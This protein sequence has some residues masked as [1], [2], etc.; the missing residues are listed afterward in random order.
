MQIANHL[1]DYRISKR[2]IALTLL[3]ANPS[4]VDTLLGG[5]EKECRAVKE[6]IARTQSEVLEPLQQL[7][8]NA[9]TACVERLIREC[10]TTGERAGVPITIRRFPGSGIHP[11]ALGR[12]DAVRHPLCDL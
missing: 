8:M 2:A 11:P 3:S 6:I 1:P 12:G 7:I 4:L 5:R 10:Q 9:R